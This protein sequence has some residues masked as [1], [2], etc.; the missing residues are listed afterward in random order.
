MKTQRI[1]VL[2]YSLFSRYYMTIDILTL[3][4]II[5]SHLHLFV[6]SFIVCRA[7]NKDQDDI[8]IFSSSVLVLGHSSSIKIF[9]LQ[10]LHQ[11]LSFL[12]RLPSL[13]Q[14]LPSRVSTSMFSLS[15]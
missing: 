6:N 9:N 10:N 14:R 1:N 11:I 8:K 13:R 15:C 2:L 7:S 4:L 12:S 5:R 3:S